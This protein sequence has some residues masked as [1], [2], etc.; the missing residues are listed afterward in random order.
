[1]SI[2]AIQTQDTNRSPFGAIAKGSI[3]GGILGYT[4]KHMLPL[5]ESEMDDEFKNVVTIIRE[6][7]HKA[8]AKAIENIRSIKDKTPA[9]DTFIKMVD[10]EAVAKGTKDATIARAF[11]MK[12]I[13]SEAKLDHGNTLELKGIIAGVNKKAVEMH[14]LCV[15]AYKGAIKSKRVTP[16]YIAAGAVLGFFVGLGHSV[17]KS[18]S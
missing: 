4:A 13:I 18:N 14:N 7:T 10:S 8:K 15:K 12:K 17:L 6:Q 2:E 16:V 5:S 3:G 11:N 1:M 9:Q